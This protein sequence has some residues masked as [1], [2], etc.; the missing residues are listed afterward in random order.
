MAQE[1][2]REEEASRWKN[3][4]INERK[5]QRRR[6]NLNETGML[7]IKPCRGDNRGNR[8]RK[9]NNENQRTR[10]VWREKQ[11]TAAKKNVVLGRSV[12]SSKLKK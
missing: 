5:R 9:I 10:P 12:I 3:I 8:R 1:N 11:L 4:S 7:R 2:E 6:R